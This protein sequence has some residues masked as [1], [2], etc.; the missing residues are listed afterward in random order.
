ME[1]RGGEIIP[2]SDYIC[3]THTINHDRVPDCNYFYGRLNQQGN[4]EYG[5][6]FINNK[7]SGTKRYQ[8]VLYPKNEVCFEYKGKMYF[9]WISNA[10]GMAHWDPRVNDDFDIVENNIDTTADPAAAEELLELGKGCVYGGYLVDK[11]TTSRF[12][13]KL[14]SLPQDSVLRNIF[15]PFYEERLQEKLSYWDML[16]IFNVTDVYSINFSID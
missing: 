6:L 4:V 11:P 15:L 9:V 7:Y 8:S 2:L 3:I 16:E 10:V 13:E 5:E 14:R 1:H 12:V